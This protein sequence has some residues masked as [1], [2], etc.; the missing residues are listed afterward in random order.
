MKAAPF[1]YMRPAS[2]A[3]AVSALVSSG[4]DAKVLA[5]GQNLVPMLNMRLAAPRVVVDVGGIEGLDTIRFDRE[6]EI[7][8]TARY[9]RV[10]RSP[11]VREHAPLLAEGIRLVGDP[12]VRNR[13]TIG[14]SLAQGDPSGEMPMAALALDATV[15]VEGPAGVRTIPARHLF[16][17]PYQTA[18]E[19][20]L[21]HI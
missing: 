6:L 12:L 4:G 7:G 14:G 1:E 21:I 15:R 10:E 17:G 2:V 20:S 16:V 5:G 3:E 11:L 13:G 9:A 8:A 19:L 18:L